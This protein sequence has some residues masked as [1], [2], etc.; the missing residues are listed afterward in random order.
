MRFE[1][2]GQQFLALNAGPQFPFT[3][4]VSLSVHCVNQ[5]EVDDLWARLTEGSSASQCG[6]LKDRFGLSWQ[7]VRRALVPDPTM[8]QRI[9]R[10]K[11]TLRQT[12]R[13]GGFLA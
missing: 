3:E 9:V 10:A 5:A 13:V 6:R 12:Q 2:E 4:A 8:A 7:I 11:R 1:L